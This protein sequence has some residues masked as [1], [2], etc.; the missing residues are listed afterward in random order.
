[1]V[2]AACSARVVLVCALI[3][4]KNKYDDSRFFFLLIWRSCRISSIEHDMR[5]KGMTT[6][7]KTL[8]KRN[9]A[10]LTLIILP[11]C[12]W[13]LFINFININENTRHT[14]YRPI[15]WQ[16]VWVFDSLLFQFVSHPAYQLLLIIF[17]AKEINT[18]NILNT[19]YL[20]I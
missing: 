8:S 15:G 16:P 12:L 17:L 1:M 14:T 4:P 13:N 20:L 5:R 19:Q 6:S 2:L 10:H 9:A 7:S 3:E 18:H 11:M